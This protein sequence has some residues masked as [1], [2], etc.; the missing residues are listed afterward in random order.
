MNCVDWRWYAFKKRT[1]QEVRL[2]FGN[3]DE[4]ILDNIIE[5]LKENRIS[6]WFELYR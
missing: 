4:E 1:E 6:K 5:E 3:I 2:K